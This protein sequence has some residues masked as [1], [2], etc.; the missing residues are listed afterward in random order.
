ML[1]N[2][3]RK[4]INLKTGILKDTRFNLKYVQLKWSSDQIIIC[5]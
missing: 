2:L 1:Q 3:S 4:T 5:Y